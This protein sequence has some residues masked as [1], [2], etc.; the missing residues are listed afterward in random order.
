MISGDRHDHPGFGGEMVMKSFLSSW[1]LFSISCL[2]FF[3]IGI[4]NHI[5]FSAI[6]VP[7]GWAVAT[8]I[9]VFIVRFS[10]K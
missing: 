1:I 10:R 6:I 5:P 8:I 9:R 4:I 3:Y 2:T 7:T